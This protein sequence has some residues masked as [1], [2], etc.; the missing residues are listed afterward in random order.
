MMVLTHSPFQPTPDS[1]DWDPKTKSEAE[2]QDVKHFADM[3]AYTDQMVGRVVAKLEELKLNENTLLIFIGDNGT[4]GSVT[5]RFNG[6][7]F[8]GGK[9][10]TTHRGTHVP[11]LVSWPAA[12]KQPSVNAD[13]IS[14][15]DFLPTICEA[16]GIDEPAEIDGVSFLPQLRGEVGKPREWLYSWYSPRQG[17]DL[18]VQ[19]CAF[20]HRFKLYRTGDFFDLTKDPDEKNALAVATLNGDTAA[21]ASSLQATL[22]RFKDV[23]PAELDRQLKNS[24]PQSNKKKKQNSKAKAIE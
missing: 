4:L 16:A 13:L 18:T 5:S 2:Q 8:K 11:C 24:N 17:T 19:E 3:T 20:D 7:D 6:S 15:T 12:T 1:P 21:A 22:D 14:S 9:G 23:R 10:K